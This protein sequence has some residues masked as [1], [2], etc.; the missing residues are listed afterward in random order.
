MISSD[1]ADKLAK[2]ILMLGATSDGEALGAA[3][4]IVRTL[5]GAGLDLHALATHIGPRVD[6]NGYDLRQ[7][8]QPSAAAGWN[9]ANHFREGRAVDEGSKLPGAP[10]LSFGLP[11]YT[12]DVIESWQEVG[13]HCLKLNREVPKKH[14][15]RSLRED[16][17]RLLEDLKRG[18]WPTNQ[19]AAHAA[20]IVAR[21]HQARDTARADK[22]RT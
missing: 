15:G 22:E 17:V 2:L 7:G 16:E 5:E 13:R 10:A 18:I 1:T 19:K 4:A 3:R 9:F 6:R 11:L 20:T 14:G 8:P 12:P 21:C